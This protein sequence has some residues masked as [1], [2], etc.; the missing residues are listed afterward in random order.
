MQD[1]TTLT[2]TSSR[3]ED[4]SNLHSW[5]P[6]IH[7]DYVLHYII[8][9]E[10]YFRT[11]S[12]YYHIRAGQS[13]LI[14]PGETVHYYPS[15]ENPWTYG[16]VNFHGSQVQELLDMTGFSR[17]PVS[18]QAELTGIFQQFSSQ[19]WQTH[20]RIRNAGLLRVLLSHYIETYPA[21]SQ[22]QPQDYL[23]SAKQLIDANFFRSDFTVGELSRKIGIER[24]YLFRIFKEQ[25]GVSVIEYL[26]HTRLEH[27]R[28]MLE[29]GVGPIKLIAYSVGYENPLYFS[30]AF[31]KRFGLS[32]KHYL[33][34]SKPPA[35]RLDQASEEP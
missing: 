4:C 18:P 29:D 2:V 6:G 21:D 22:R 19:I 28:Q 8:R 33:L 32:P 20:L 13:F 17:C 26:I 9:G 30:N 16:W 31:K 12:Q 24:T 11:G 1:D 34:Q 3:I 23:R 7:T 35:H 27:A 14:R 5:G 25:E 10:G 15:P